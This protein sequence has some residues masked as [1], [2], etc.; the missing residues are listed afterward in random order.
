MGRADVNARDQVSHITVTYELDIIL[1]N[2]ALDLTLSELSLC[3]NKCIKI[4]L[5]KKGNTFKAKSLLFIILWNNA[6][7]TSNLVNTI[8]NV[9]HL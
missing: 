4:T 7:F 8:V 9:R 3:H 5:Y 2:M 1:G 6:F